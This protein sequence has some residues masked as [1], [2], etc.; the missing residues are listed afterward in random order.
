MNDGRTTHD[1][2]APLAYRIADQSLDGVGLGDLRIGDTWAGFAYLISEAS[3]ARW[4]SP[5]EASDARWGDRKRHAGQHEAATAIAVF[6]SDVSASETEPEAVAVKQERATVA[7]E[8]LY[9]AWAASAFTAATD[10]SCASC[11]WGH[12]S[13]AAV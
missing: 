13:G 5:S 11:L 6:S 9:G 8:G 3:G 10:P 1:E 12:P 2:A 7:T 4:A